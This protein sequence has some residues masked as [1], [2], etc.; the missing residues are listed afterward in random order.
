[1]LPLHDDACCR[2]GKSALTLEGRAHV[3][4][5]NALSAVAHVLDAPEDQRKSADDLIWQLGSCLSDWV[6]AVQISEESK[7]K[8]PSNEFVDVLR[9]AGLDKWLEPGSDFTSYPRE[10]AKVRVLQH[11]DFRRPVQGGLAKACKSCQF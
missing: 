8:K 4:A 1:M 3:A 5:C 10:L 9:K 7:Q 6:Q 2:D 11:D